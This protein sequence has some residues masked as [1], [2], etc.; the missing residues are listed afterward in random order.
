MARPGRATPAASAAERVAAEV[1]E[2]VLEGRLAPGTPLTET[3]LASRFAVS[4]TTVREALRA[5]AHRGL[6]R[7]E[8]HRGATVTLLTGEDLADLGRARGA[9]EGAAAEAAVAADLA[10][11]E[12]ALAAMDAAVGRREADAVVE[13]DLAFHAALVALLGS[14]RLDAAYAALQSELRLALAVA[15]RRVAS[16]GK[17]AE[18]G[19]LLALAREGDAAALRAALVAHISAGVA[20]QRAALGEGGAPDGPPG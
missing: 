18:H 10:A 8:R 5:L 15:G 3:A 14:R 19:R 16:P 9:L 17:V 2:D 11:L 4:R 20:D 12:A 6:V 13:A 7:L 1:R